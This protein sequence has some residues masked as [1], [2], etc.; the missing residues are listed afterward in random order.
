MESNI[1]CLYIVINRLYV[2]VRLSKGWDELVGA[3]WPNRNFPDLLMSWEYAGFYPPE[4]E[5]AFYLCPGPSCAF[6]GE[7]NDVEI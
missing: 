3:T 6:E 7:E 5:G 1:Y 2:V 4:F